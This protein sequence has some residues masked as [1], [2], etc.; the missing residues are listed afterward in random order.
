MHNNYIKL[1]KTVVTQK[2]FPTPADREK[3]SQIDRGD[4]TLATLQKP[5]RLIE[6]L[7]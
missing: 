2:E 1:G 6:T 7:W 5:S 4:L 3:S